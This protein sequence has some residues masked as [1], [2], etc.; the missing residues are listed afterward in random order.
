MRRTW[1]LWIVAAA[2]LA[3]ALAWAVWRMRD[4]APAPP[5]AA[6]VGAGVRAQSPA[7][8]AIDVGLD[9]AITVTFDRPAVLTATLALAA[10]DPSAASLPQPLL[11]TASGDPGA[12]VPGE[13][14][15]LTPAI[16]SFTPRGRLHAAETYTVSLR[17]E[18]AAAGSAP[19][20]FSTGWELV[21]GTRPYDGAAEVPLD[22]PVTVYLGP[23]VDAASAAERFRLAVAESDAALP[24]ELRQIQGG[25]I[26]TPAAPLGPGVTYEGRIL[27][28][29]R[30]ARGAPLP[31]EPVAWRFSTEGALELLAAHP[32]TD[33]AAVDER[34]RLTFSRPVAEPGP[35]GEGGRPA[36]DLAIDPPVAG[37]GRW[38]TADT[39]VFSPTARLRPLTTYDVA[40]SLTTTRGGR[41]A[42]VSE[43]WSFST[44]AVELRVVEARRPSVPI[45]SQASLA[46]QSPSTP[47]GPFQLRFSLPV[48]A[49]SVADGVRLVRRDA[50]LPVPGIATAS[51][52]TV[53]FTPTLPLIRG[54][55]YEIEVTP[56]LTALGGAVRASPARA[57]TFRIAPPPALASSLPANGASGVAWGPAARAGALIELYFNVEMDHDSVV[58][59]LT[60]TPAIPLLPQRNDYSGSTLRFDAGLRPSTTYTLIVGA[61]ARDVYGEALGRDVSVTFRTRAAAP[62]VEIVTS[63]L[64]DFSATVP[65]FLPARLSFGNG[66]FFATYSAHAP[67]RVALRHV[68]APQVDAAIYRLD[69]AEVVPLLASSNAWRDF[70]P[71][72]DQLAGRVSQALAAQPDRDWLDVLNLGALEPGLYYLAVSAPG[73][74][75]DAQLM[76]VSPYALTIKHSPGQ[77]FVW[78]VDLAD[79][80]PAAD[81]PLTLTLLRT[82]EPVTR[83]IGRT[84]ADGVLTTD[85]ATLNLPPPG[86][87]AG[88]SFV[89]SSPAGERYSFT[90]S[91]W[92]RDLQPYD[93]DIPYSTGPVAS[94]VVGNLY[95]DRPLYRP[96]NE[97][98]LRGIA[99][100][101]D[102][103]VYLLPRAGQEVRLTVVDARGTVIAD[104]TAPLNDTG[105]FSTSLRLDPLAPLGSYGVFATL[106]GAPVPR[107]GSHTLIEYDG[108][109]FPDHHFAGSFLVLAFSKPALQVSVTPAQA[110]VLP[111]DTATFTVEARYYTG[112][113]A[114]NAKVRWGTTIGPPISR[115]AQAEGFQ[116]GGADGAPQVFELPSNAFA[117]QGALD[118]QGRLVVNVPFFAIGDEFSR[119]FYV[120]VTEPAGGTV[121]YGVA[122]IVG[123]PGGLAIGIRPASMAAPAGE[124]RTVELLVVDDGEQPLA[125]EGVRVSVARREWFSVR[126]E[127]SDGRFYW[128]STSTDTQLATADLVSDDQGLA[129]FGFTPAEGGAYL[130]TAEA[131]DERGNLVRS[132]EL[133][134]A[135]GGDAFWGIDSTSHVEILPDRESYRP[136]E[137]ARLFIPAPYPD[138]RALVTVERGS[139]LSYSLHTLS[140]TSGLIELPIAA[141]HTPNI[142]VSVVLIKPADADLPVP[143]LRMGMVELPVPAD[144]QLLRVEVTPDPAE[145]GPGERAS[146]T[147]E[148]TD[149]MGSPV[150]ADVALALVDRRLLDLYRLATGRNPTPGY[151]EGFFGRRPPAVQTANTLVQLA[152]RTALRVRP[153]AKGGA[154]PGSRPQ[155]IGSASVEDDRLLRREFRDTAL[156]MPAVRTGPDGVARVSVDLPDNLTTWQM[157]ARA[158]TAGTRFGQGEARLVVGRAVQIE[159]I[160]PEAL[161]VGDR[162]TLRATLRNRGQA[163]V[164]VVATL[165]A[166]GLRLLGDEIQTARLE[167]G[168]EAAVRWEVAAD[169]AGTARLAFRAAAGF[170]R[171]GVELELP[172]RRFVGLDRALAGGQVRDE[173]RLALELPPPT[174]AAAGRELVVSLLPSLRAAVA[175]GLRRLDA[176]ADAGSEQT[177]SSFL[178]RLQAEALGLDLAAAPAGLSGR[179][180]RLYQLQNLDGGWGWWARD[181]ASSPYLTVYA[182]EG[183]TAARAAGQQVDE[184]AYERALGYVRAALNDGAFGGDE[185][186]RLTTRAYA[187]YVLTLAGEG[188]IGRVAALYDRRAELDR[189]GRAYLLLTLHALGD[190]AR[191]V[192]PLAAELSAEAA[193]AGGG[194]VLWRDVAPSPQ[195]LASDVRTTALVAR[196]LLRA[197]P[198]SPLVPGA[199]RALLARSA[200]GAAWDTGHESAAALVTLAEVGLRSAAGQGGVGYQVALGDRLI[201]EGLLPPDEAAGPLAVTADAAALPAQ[202]G[203]ELRL[204]RRA[205]PFERGRPPMGYV[206][207][208]REYE[209]PAEAAPLDS[210]LAVERRYVAVDP[211]TLVPGIV[212]V[213]EAPL[214]GLVQV[215]LT[216]TVPEAAQFLLVEDRLPAGLEPVAV[217]PATPEG[218]PPGVEATG[219]AAARPFSHVELHRD[220]VALYAAAVGRGTYTYTY[221]AR[222]VV[223]GEFQAP[224]ATARLAYEPATFGRSA[225]ARLTIEE[226]GTP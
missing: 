212:P 132:S 19:W 162:A 141:E 79:G 221:L 191:R 151:A 94:Q 144:E 99:R 87:A 213:D 137:T 77:L 45:A 43:S 31:Y 131:T 186:W 181:G 123:R 82:G 66:D 214:T 37:E 225:G 8:G 177:V 102:D 83:S 143:E 153:G 180:Q 218:L 210:G 114:A 90:S 187:L 158:V 18:L 16:Y 171:D 42:T 152:D 119:S 4:A 155:L 175:E 223:A 5:P 17:P 26:F 109:P 52:Q 184:A 63:L 130:V 88:Y 29:A 48:D 224:P 176:Q 196:A 100:V 195:T 27:A 117:Q 21:S 96:G 50:S 36:P 68:N 28:G 14:Q 112:E 86:S 62:D 80:R 169:D 23:D 101:D 92:G 167:P 75:G 150:E 140:G 46:A 170:L 70:A 174:P 113:P 30:T 107:N 133:I 91:T 226:P 89:L 111:N 105:S 220:R 197:D 35:A 57:G 97:V 135:S 78:A 183:L 72:P 182:L 74:E 142:F 136:G 211:N 58:Q 60:I 157:V 65:S 159:P 81:L 85:F 24:G 38:V 147:V 10:D 201:G 128:N 194:G 156:W 198:A 205:G 122:E 200:D 40:A 192:E 2:A 164:D 216:V 178:A 219:A 134:Y 139:V 25:F 108:A 126:E 165:E 202:G 15:W 41:P 98:F 64:P 203:S 34:I 39:Y 190:Q 148:V 173:A 204:V 106:E 7:P 110:V 11:V 13:G 69:E 61:A 179:L 54:A 116:F 189:A 199:A 76:A 67:I 12:P 3:P 71:R 154:G 49:A 163:A 125:G 95:S 104:E 20:S 121:S 51:G 120:E 208:L 168:G 207:R 222:A 6:V 115:A 1:L 53:V 185:P 138:M 9:S 193:P 33:T 127:G 206:V 93:F 215:R 172:V 129:R 47:F 22:T 209:R 59:N 84:N 149:F 44:A 124:Q 56:A 160:L 146:F 118:A 32:V 188:D 55:T 161:L 145:A 166:T 73:G 217:A 103:G